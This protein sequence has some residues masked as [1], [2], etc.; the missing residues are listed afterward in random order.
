MC[1]VTRD[2]KHK[3]FQRMP[4][5]ISSDNYQ[6][7]NLAEKDLLAY[8]YRFEPDTGQLRTSQ[9]IKKFGVTKKTIQRWLRK[10]RDLGL[11]RIEN[12]GTIHRLIHTTQTGWFPKKQ[13][14]A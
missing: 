7:I 9:L 14:T 2:T 13:L 12:P 4:K 6:L 1:K 3:K 5:W 11:I 10:L 8:I